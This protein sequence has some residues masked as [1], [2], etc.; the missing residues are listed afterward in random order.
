MDRVK[1]TNS[2]RDRKKRNKK[3]GDYVLTPPKYIEKKSTLNTVN[4]MAKKFGYNTEHDENDV[5]RSMRVN[6]MNDMARYIGG[7][8]FT[9]KQTRFDKMKLKE[10]KGFQPKVNPLIRNFGRTEN[11][12]RK[13]LLQDGFKALKF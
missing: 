11:A 6:F 12:L 13:I 7:K 4:R 10:E 2:E 1:I 5:L 8:T 3:D 9:K